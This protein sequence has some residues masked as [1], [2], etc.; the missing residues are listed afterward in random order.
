LW[1]GYI[2]AR[3]FCYF[4]QQWEKVKRVE[5]SKNKP[6]PYSIVHN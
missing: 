2:S 6:N 1:K 3:F 5:K 4:L